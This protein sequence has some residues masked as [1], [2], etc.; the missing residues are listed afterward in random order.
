MKNIL[1]DLGSNFYTSSNAFYKK[2]SKYIIPLFSK[3]KF[4]AHATLCAGLGGT[5]WW[6]PGQQSDVLAATKLFGDFAGSC[7]SKFWVPVRKKNGRSETKRRMKP[8]CI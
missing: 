1:C 3:L 8:H 7:T 5:E 6:V 4:P 2:V